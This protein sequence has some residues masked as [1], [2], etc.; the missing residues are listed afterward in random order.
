MNPDRAIEINER[1]VM[2]YMVREKLSDR[3]LPDLTDVSLTEAIE[4]SKIIEGMEPREDPDHPGHKI[5]S[6]HVEPTR[7]HQ[8]WFWATAKR[9]EIDI[10]T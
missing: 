9:H 7:V 5:Y 3:P 10:E 4:A 2:A 6:C 1:L 8:L